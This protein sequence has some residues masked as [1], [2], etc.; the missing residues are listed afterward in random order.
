M[1]LSFPGYSAAADLRCGGAGPVR[2]ALIAARTRTLSLADAYA[3]VLAA[4]GMRVPYRPTL[5]PPL[6]EWGHVG[7]FQ[8]YWI[9]R[10]RQRSA[11]IAC[12]PAHERAASLLAAADALYDSGRVEHRSR[13][14]LDLPSAAATREYLDGTLQQ[15]LELLDRLP[16]GAGDDDLYFFRLVALHEAMHAEAAM[17]MARELAVPVPPQPHVAS[18]IGA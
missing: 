16:P 18:S 1:D 14:A 17:Y 8:E 3:D 15:T 5:N 4:S 12:D 13:W 2:Q 9:A 10:N 11:G 7:W 6:W